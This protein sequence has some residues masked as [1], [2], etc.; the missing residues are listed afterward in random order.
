MLT[1]SE[2]ICPLF[3]TNHENFERLLES[4]ALFEVRTVNLFWFDYLNCLVQ[5]MQYSQNWL[6]DSTLDVRFEAKTI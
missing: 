2:E 3:D 5:A 1:Q 6:L 4:K